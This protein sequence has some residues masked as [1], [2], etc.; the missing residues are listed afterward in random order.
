MK[1]WELMSVMRGDIG[2]VRSVAARRSEWAFLVEWID[3]YR[4]IV[5]SQ[6]RDKLDYALDDKFSLEVLKRCTLKF[7]LTNRGV[8]RSRKFSLFDKTLSAAQAFKQF[9]GAALE[10]ALEKGSASSSPS[11]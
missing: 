7:Y 8:L 4:A 9:G 1:F 2:T 11:A 3:N 6:D 5:G 10:E